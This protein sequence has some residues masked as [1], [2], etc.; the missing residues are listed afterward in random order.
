MARTLGECELAAMRRVVETAAK[1]LQEAHA[2][3]DESSYPVRYRA[4]YGALARLAWA[5]EWLG[6]L[7]AAMEREKA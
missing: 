7:Q 4:P 1:T 2:I 5:Q 6:F 3:H